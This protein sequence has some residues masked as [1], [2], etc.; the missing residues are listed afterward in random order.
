ME[1]IVNAIISG[2]TVGIGSKPLNK[3][4]LD[5]FIEK[6]SDDIKNGFIVIKEIKIT[7]VQMVRTC[8]TNKQ[9]TK[10]K[11]W[12]DYINVKLRKLGFKT[13]WQL[14]THFVTK[15]IIPK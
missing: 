12:I 3:K 4:E 7:T 2:E 10:D 6:Y 13:D 5:A 11:K 9:N 14:K 1:D 15:N 8:P